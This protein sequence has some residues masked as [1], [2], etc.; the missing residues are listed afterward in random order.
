MAQF[1]THREWDFVVRGELPFK[2]PALP[3]N[4]DALEPHIDAR[5][6]E[7]QHGR[8]QLDFA[9]GFNRAIGQVIDLYVQ[10]K[11]KGYFADQSGES[12]VKVLNGIPERLPTPTREY[13]WSKELR[14]LIR[15]NALGYYNHALFWQMM[16]KGGGGEPKG[17]LA[18]AINRTF[19]SF[20]A[21]K[22]EFT[23]AALAQVG[24]GWVWLTVDAGA[25][26]VEALPNE[27]NPL[28]LGRP[29]L[30]GLDLWE[31]AYYLQYQDRRADYVNAWFNVVDWD[32][33][34]E[35]YAK[36]KS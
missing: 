20:S 30:L 2:L 22:A 28:S 5:T 9:T 14:V 4:Y 24:S 8:I 18:K 17:D 25:L 23:K 13:V 34:A 36:A 12:V 10:W 32:F 16:R 6:V 29:V 27:D 26:K 19:G 1:L 21:F 15:L 7:I 3:Y 33:A 31:H 11:L 35:R